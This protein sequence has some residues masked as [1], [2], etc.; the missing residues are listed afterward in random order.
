VI[1][2]GSRAPGTTAGVVIEERT[3]PYLKPFVVRLDNGRICYASES[4]LA[5]EDDPT[6]APL[7]PPIHKD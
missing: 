7:G 1:L 5:L 3:E 2:L 6:R 4:E